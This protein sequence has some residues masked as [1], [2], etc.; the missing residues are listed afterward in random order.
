[1]GFFYIGPVDGHNMDDLLTVLRNIKARENYGPVLIHAMTQKGKGYKPA[2]I[3][4]DKMHGVAKFD[5][6]TGSQ[7]KPKSNRPAF[8]KVFANAL[9]KEAKRDIRRGFGVRGHEAIRHNLFHLL[10]TR[11]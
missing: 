7:F 4:K 6:V 5:I 10:A 11:I 3:A 8:T 2:E 9:I 1:M